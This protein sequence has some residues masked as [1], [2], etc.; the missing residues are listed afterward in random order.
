MLL[1]VENAT[2]LGSMQ[3][4]KWV[5]CLSAFLKSA[6]LIYFFS[7]V[8]NVKNATKARDFY[9]ILSITWNRLHHWF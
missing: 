1:H 9:F 7:I 8:N 2:Q 3:L 4:V 6:F 5:N